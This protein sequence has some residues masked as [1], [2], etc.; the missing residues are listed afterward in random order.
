LLK[1]DSGIEVQF[2]IRNYFDTLNVEWN[3]TAAGQ[4]IQSPA[5]IALNQGETATIIREINF[6]TRGVKPVKITVFSGNFSDTYSENVRLYSLDLV[7]FLNIIKNGT[8][9]IFTF[10]IQNDWTNL[11]AYWN[12]SNPVIENTTILDTN[13]SLIVV[14]EENYGQGQKEVEI[15]LYNQTTLE[16]RITEIFTIKEIGI[17]EFEVLHQNSSNAITS[18]LIINNINPL[19]IS[20][21]LNNSQKLISSINNTELATNEQ[22]LIIV[23]S[24]FSASGVYPLNFLIN[25]STKNDNASGVAMS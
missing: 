25:S 21:R 18:A 23:E 5:P 20:W 14:I 16:D 15:R 9:R 13:E 1:G 6:T 11:T 12:I 19:N 3:I 8:T 7:D 24:N 22:A 10:I 17:N 4:T 2:Q